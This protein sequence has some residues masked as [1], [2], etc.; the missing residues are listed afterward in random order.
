MENYSNE[1]TVDDYVIFQYE[2]ELFPGKITSV[3]NDG[4]IIRSMTRSGLNWKCP[5]DT[6][7]ML[8]MNEDIKQK[9][10]SPKRLKRGI[11][12]VTEL[13]ARWGH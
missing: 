2:E 1:Y 8:Y 3:Q 6:D 11:L 4:C 10:N 9:I 7:E 12:E 13:R 5:K